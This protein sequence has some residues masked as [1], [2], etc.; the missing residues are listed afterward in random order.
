LIVVPEP[1]V[2]AYERAR[3]AIAFCHSPLPRTGSRIGRAASTIRAVFG[4]SVRSRAPRGIGR[5]DTGAR[6]RNARRLAHRADQPT[7]IENARP[8]YEIARERRQPRFAAGAG[9]MGF[10]RGRAPACPSDR[11][12]HAARSRDFH[13]PSVAHAASAAKAFRS[14]QPAQEAAVVSR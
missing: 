14:I 7:F 12:V 2:A 13:R 5:A 6:P 10:M 11:I 1:A 9:S 4:D 8:L 3:G